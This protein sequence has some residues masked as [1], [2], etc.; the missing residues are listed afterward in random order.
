M[1]V[2]REV[3]HRDGSARRRLTSALALS[4][5]LAAVTGTAGGGPQHGSQQAGSDPPGHHPSAGSDRG[6]VGLD[7]WAQG[8]L[9]DVVLA[10]AAAGGIELH[11]TRSRDGGLTW[12]PEVNIPTPAPVPSASRGNEPQIAARGDLVLVVWTAPGTSPWGTGPLATARSRDGGASWQPGANPA[13]DGSTDGHGF[14]DLAVDAAGR[15]QA[16]W[17]DKRGGSQGLRAASSDDA[18]R[19]SAN[20]T[21]DPRTCE[22]CWN[23]LLAAADGSLHVLYRDHGPRDMAVASRPA[24]NGGW[25]RRGS[26]GAFGWDIDACPHS[27]G[28]LVALAPAAGASPSGAASDTAAPRLLASVWTGAGGRV[29]TYVVEPGGGA[30]AAWPL[31]DPTAKHSDL[32]ALG[33]RVLVAWEGREGTVGRVRAAQ[34]AGGG[35]RFGPVVELSTPGIAA[36]HP[37]VLPVA[38]R[39]LVLWTERQE[40]RSRWASYRVAIGPAAAAAAAGR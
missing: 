34:V 2:G 24:G 10:V 19:W 22:C 11:H 7:G 9:V 12:S 25:Q 16:V 31:P 6:V 14:I 18:L 38:D 39:F 27:G 29:G 36:Q 21:V 37:L 35:R 5:L 40:G 4:A 1:A 17:L 33:D 8:D 15:F 30:A 32:A 23:R 28:G 3:R 20:A 26:A 13:D